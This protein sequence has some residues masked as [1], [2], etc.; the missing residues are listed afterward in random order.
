MA[1]ASQ[2]S[3]AGKSRGPSL[4]MRVVIMGIRK[5]FPSVNHLSCRQVDELSKS[6]EV[7]YLVTHLLICNDI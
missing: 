5:R 3:S 2:D 4:S 1:E 7:V 6:K